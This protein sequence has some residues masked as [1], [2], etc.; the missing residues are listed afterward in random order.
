MNVGGFSWTGN[1]DGEEFK[2][3]DDGNPIYPGFYKEENIRI[4]VLGD[5][6]ELDWV[7]TKT[8]LAIKTPEKQ[9]KYAYVFKIE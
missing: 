4:T 9:G 5:R 3:T 2:V 1:Y 6:Q 7:M 8:D